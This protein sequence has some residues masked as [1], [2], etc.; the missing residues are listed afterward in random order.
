MSKLAWKAVSLVI[1]ILGGAAAGAIFRRVWKIARCSCRGVGITALE[2]SGG[3]L[4][5]PAILSFR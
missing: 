2:G 4:P 5:L 1:S 3:V